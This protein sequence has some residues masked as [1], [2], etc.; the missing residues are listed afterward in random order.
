VLDEHYLPEDENAKGEEI[1]LANCP[2]QYVPRSIYEFVREYDHID[3]FPNSMRL[4]R[5]EMS[6]LFLEAM[7]YYEQQLDAAREWVRKHNG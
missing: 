6:S 7:D 4:A 5:G 2:R 3:R 1:L